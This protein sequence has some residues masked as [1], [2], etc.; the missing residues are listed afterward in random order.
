MI[1][2]YRIAFIFIA[3]LFLAGCGN[4]PDIQQNVFK[5]PD[6]L[7]DP[8]VLK[9]QN[10]NKFASQKKFD[11]VDDE[12]MTTISLNKFGRSNPFQPF[13]QRSLTGTNISKVSNLP[14][15]NID[16][17]PPPLLNNDE[18]IPKFLSIKVNGILYDTAGSSAIVN[19]NNSDYVVHKGDFIFQ[20]S[21]VMITPT[22]VVL[23]YKNNI[24]KVAIGDI[25][26]GS[27]NYD[28]V[29]RMRLYT[30]ANKLSYMIDIRQKTSI[31][32]PLV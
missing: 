9:N 28:P 5:N 21:V 17:P 13:A 25:I 31:R 22:N 32:S 7:K 15:L 4:Q 23:R 6:M 10:L 27:I 14:K 24:F 30:G 3:G 19:V 11:Y 16:V 1:K 8:S 29:R 20:Y 18:N 12:K 2:L 26:D